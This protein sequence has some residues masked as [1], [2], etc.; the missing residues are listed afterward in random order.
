MLNYEGQREKQEASSVAAVVPDAFRSGNFSAISTPLRD[1]LGG[2]FVGNQIPAS[3]INPVSL[4]YLEIHPRPNQPGLTANLAGVDQQINNTNQVFTRGD[5]NIGDNDKLFARV[6]IFRYDFPTI[7][8]NFF[9]PVNSRITAGNAV[10]SE[11]HIFSPTLIN[12][13]KIGFTQWICGNPR[14]L[15]SMLKRWTPVSG[16][17]CLRMT[18][19]WILLRPGTY[20]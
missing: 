8:I 15:D 1:P 11:T 6:A 19:R 2:T 4:R 7:P 14:E 13:A 5:H 3:R 18:V 9:S 10:I 17:A 20:R 16:P 12:E